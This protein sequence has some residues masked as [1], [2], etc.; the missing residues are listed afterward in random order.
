MDTKD[1]VEE[2]LAADCDVTLQPEEVM[3]LGETAEGVPAPALEPGPTRKL[4][5]AEM[6]LL[7][8][9][10]LGEA[11]AYSS[12]WA[13]VAAEA[14]LVLTT[15]LTFLS[16]YLAGD[17]QDFSP[18][19]A[20]DLVVNRP[21]EGYSAE[22]MATLKVMHM[23]G[24]VVGDVLLLPQ[25]FVLVIAVDERAGMV[26]QL[27]CVATLFTLTLLTQSVQKIIMNHAKSCHQDNYRGGGDHEAWGWWLFFNISWLLVTVVIRQ[28]F[29]MR[30][31]TRVTNLKAIGP[32]INFLVSRKSREY[33][34]LCLLASL[35]AAI[36]SGL[37]I[38][39]AALA[40][41]GAVVAATL[42][43][44]AMLGAQVALLAIYL[45]THIG[46]GHLRAVGRGEL[47]AAVA[48]LGEE[49]REVLEASSYPR[50][51]RPFTRGV[52]ARRPPQVLHPRQSGQE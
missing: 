27:L 8:R 12:T 31:R 10:G 49:H 1:V 20:A 35:G 16:L 51:Y 37:H 18:L 5:L 30:L 15:S 45:V 25:L 6:A 4:R 23:T 29:G 34:A 21:P 13:V 14:L 48:R 50:K 32:V 33:S 42:A 26:W 22:D 9:L 2:I 3:A 7:E 46:Y 47:E 28:L 39:T 24:S 11:P 41:T 36:L 52:Q 17:L 38:Y 43:T 19:A 40:H 44:V